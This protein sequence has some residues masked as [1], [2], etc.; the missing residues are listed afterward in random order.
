MESTYSQNIFKFGD[1]KKVNSLPKVLIPANY[2]ASNVIIEI[3]VVNKYIPLLLS[4]E[5]RTWCALGY[6][7]PPS[8]HQKFVDPL[9]IF[10]DD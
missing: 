1:G 9:I 10:V 3:D 6:Q 4:K 7:P 8:P 2:G 5:T